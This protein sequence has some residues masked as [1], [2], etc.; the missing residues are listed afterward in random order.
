MRCGFGPRWASAHREP[1]SETTSRGQRH[2]RLVFATPCW[3]RAV[4][5][6]RFTFYLSHSDLSHTT[7]YSTARGATSPERAESTRAP[8]GAAADGRTAVASLAH[9][10]KR[11]SLCFVHTGANG[12]FRDGFLILRKPIVVQRAYRVLV[13]LFL[14]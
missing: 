7:V 9:A 2:L 5:C 1:I 13:S 14:V 10:K 6:G 11:S 3:K 4:T 8:A 12:I